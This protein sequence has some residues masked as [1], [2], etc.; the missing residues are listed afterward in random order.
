MDLNNKVAVIT[1][2]SKGIGRATAM[3]LAAKGAALALSARSE[4]LLLETAKETEDLGSR[5]FCFSG[6]M[7][8]EDE[9][10]KFI[11]Q[12]VFHFG[13]IH[14]L[15]NNAGIGHFHTI[16]EM[17]T[18]RWDRMFNLNVRGAF[19]ATREAIPFLRKAGQSAVVNI[20]SLAGKNAFAEGGGYAASKHALL[21]FSRCLMLEERENGIRVLALCPGSV[22]TRF[23]HPDPQFS[24][25]RDRMLSGEDVAQAVI[26]ALQFPQ[27]AMVSEI[28]IRPTNP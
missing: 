14:I 19:I 12:S 1:G 7:S 24:S 16:A 3:A 10:K 20:I 28:D 17:P 22:S 2:A 15:I 5:T 9:I 27:R 18:E 4:K 21:A 23:N 13:H 11:R 26:C 8:K 25:K 6:D